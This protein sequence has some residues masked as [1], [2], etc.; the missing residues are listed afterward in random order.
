MAEKVLIVDDEPDMLR[1]LSMIIKE[2]TPYEVTTT[3]NPLEALELARKGSFDLLVADLKMPGLNG[4][5]L[6][7]SVKRF[8]EDIP[9]IIITAYGTVEAAVETMH[10]G[11]FDFIT[12]PFRKEQI[13]F[14]IERALKWVRVQKENKMLREQLKK[15]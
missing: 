1:L 11:A 2:K 15:Q 4:I 5:E 12:K 13:L 10:K 8:D 3:N 9:T 14:T 7:E 6:L